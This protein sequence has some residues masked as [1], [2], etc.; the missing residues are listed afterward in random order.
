M[1]RKLLIT[2]HKNKQSIP[3][4]RPFVKPFYLYV[5]AKNIAEPKNSRGEN[6]NMLMSKLGRSTDRNIEMTWGKFW[7]TVQKL[8][9]NLLMHEGVDGQARI[10]VACRE[11]GFDALFPGT[12]GIILS[13][14]YATY[15]INRQSFAEEVDVAIGILRRDLCYTANFNPDEESEWSEAGLCSLAY[16]VPVEAVS[17]PDKNE[18][19]KDQ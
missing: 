18:N 10:A 13:D 15:V 5:E 14:G 17:I 12:G 9:G 7:E 4:D 8:D 11:L 19:E 6:T 1:L 16:R 2:K 3:I